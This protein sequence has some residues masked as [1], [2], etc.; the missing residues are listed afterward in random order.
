[1]TNEPNITSN[2]LP[3]RDLNIASFLMAT[4]KVTL[5]KVERTGDKT[6]FLHFH[7]KDKAEGLISA[8]W[9]DSAPAMQPRKLFGARRDLQDLILSG[10]H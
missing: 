10:G 6:A 5:V 4:G 8:Y 3:V 9:A 1:M 2:T 7:P